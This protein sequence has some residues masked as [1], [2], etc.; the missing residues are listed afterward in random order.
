MTFD[1]TKFIPFV[2]NPAEILKRREAGEIYLADFGN[3]QGRYISTTIDSNDPVDVSIKISPKIELRLTYIFDDKQ[4]HGVQ[5]TK[6]NA[7][8]STDKIHL[9][10]LDWEKVLVLLK[11]FDGMN[12]G[13]VAS[14]SL[15]LDAG[16]VGNPEELKK[17]LTT[18]ATDSQGK[19]KLK[20]VADNFGLLAPERIKNVAKQKENSEKMKKLLENGD[21]FNTEKARLNVGKD[22]E[23]WQKFF[24]ENDWLLGSDVVEIL[25]ERI[26]DEHSTVDLP[27]K[28]VDG[29]LDII[30]LKLPNAP[31]WTEEG[32]PTA[33]LIK[34]IMQCIRYLNEA[35]KRAN[36]HAKIEALKCDI[37][38]P[39]ITLVCGQSA[40][41][42]AGQHK[43]LRIL[44]SSF[45]N[46]TILTYN[47]VLQRALKI[48]GGT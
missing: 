10:T 28:S 24:E 2:P 19:Q 35:E 42:Q 20:E 41:W 5:L 11:I 34:A 22:E 17:F 32:N 14:G 15:V 27:V 13:A 43:Q 16:I 48:T 44:N 9:S 26:L 29:F 3:G 25:D 8:G 37:V 12:L 33:E 40:G 7:D 39:R 21:F 47:H 18:V 23:V 45:H 38:K 4:V 30:E 1:F 46:I 36:D 6:L 31:F